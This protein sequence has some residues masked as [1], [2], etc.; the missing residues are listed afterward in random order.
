MSPS[1]GSKGESEWSG[2]SVQ[3]LRQAD[4][5]CLEENSNG[6]KEHLSISAGVYPGEV[7]DAN[8]Q[9]QI[10]LLDQNAHM[11]HTDR[12]FRDMCYSLKCRTP[13]REGKLKKSVSLSRKES[14]M[15][16]DHP[17]GAP[18]KVMSNNLH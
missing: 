2:C 7:W 1:R 9:C 4:L 13:T 16:S 15:K 17:G 14:C 8:R 5:H 12:N 3:S 6:V 18:I 10:F 11:D